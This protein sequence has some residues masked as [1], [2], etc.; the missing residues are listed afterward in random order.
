M[1]TLLAASAICLLGNGVLA[2]DCVGNNLIRTMS[3]TDQNWI[4]EQAEAVPYHK[5]IR[6]RARKGKALIDIVGTYHMDHPMHPETVDA[7]RPALIAADRLLVEMGPAEEAQLQSAIASDPTLIMDP[8]GAT[9]PERLSP[10]QW[11]EVGAAM[12]A[13]GVPAV[14]AS[15][16]RP[17]YIATLLAFSPCELAKMTNGS[18]D[19]DGLDQM[20]IDE[21]EAAG[22]EI[23]A[24][25]PWDSV[26]RIFSDLTPQEEID[27]IVYSL[28]M[29][30]YAED[31]TATMQEAYAAGDI[32]QIWEFGRLDAYRNSGL[33][34]PEVDRMLADAEAVLINDRNRKWIA[35]LTDAANVA[36]VKGQGVVA[37]F[38]ALH[39]PGNDGVLRLLEN[40]GW[41]IERVE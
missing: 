36:A 34:Q 11:T 27:M 37:A 12:D 26:L 13:R 1:R 41:T 6:W 22:I 20:I 2:D 40:E 10:E 16:M 9:L 23:N 28:P 30:S 21:A 5:G 7:I 4:R 39:L 32:W 3:A 8:T 35:P 14:M 38:G 29:A 19:A 15:R 17:W 24:L 31:Y 33:P 18:G 25:E